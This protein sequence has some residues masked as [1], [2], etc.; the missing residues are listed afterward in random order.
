M[1]NNKCF[2]PKQ[3]EEQFVNEQKE[4]FI[5]VINIQLKDNRE[6]TSIFKAHI[7]SEQYKIFPNRVLKEVL[8]N[9]NEKGWFIY[10]TD[11]TAG[12]GK[13]HE[14]LILDKEEETRYSTKDS[15]DKPMYRIN[16]QGIINIFS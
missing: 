2:N 10:R 8:L 12:D 3:L 4:K 1:V 13:N 11:Q 9:F 6:R 16:E 14:I 7:F 15:K 5:S